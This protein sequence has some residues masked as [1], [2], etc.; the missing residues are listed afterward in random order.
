MFKKDNPFHFLKTPE[1]SKAPILGTWN[2]YYYVLTGFFISE[3]LLFT[4]LSST[5]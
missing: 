5:Y 3:I 4:F 2:A 1:Y